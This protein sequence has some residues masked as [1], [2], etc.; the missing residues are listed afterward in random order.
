MIIP[1]ESLIVDMIHFSWLGLSWF[2]GYLP[3]LLSCGDNVSL[4]RLCSIVCFFLV[5]LG[6]S[7][8]VSL[9]SF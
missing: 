5:I 2:A 3:D 4:W 7:N 9:I 8:L 6:K 1:A